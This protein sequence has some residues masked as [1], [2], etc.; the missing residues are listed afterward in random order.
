VYPAA[1]GS[2]L[3]GTLGT[4]GCFSFFA[5]KNL[6]TGEGAWWLLIMMIWP[7]KSG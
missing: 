4:V 5:N 2:R 1:Q 3:A 7:E 6:T